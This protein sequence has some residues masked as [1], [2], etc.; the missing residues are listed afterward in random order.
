M[1]TS[2]LSD[3]FYTDHAYSNEHAMTVIWCVILCEVSISRTSQK[4]LPT[5]LGM[6]AARPIPANDKAPSVTHEWNWW[7]VHAHR[8]IHTPV[9]SF[10]PNASHRSLDYGGVLVFQAGWFPF[11]YC[12]VFGRQT[13]PFLPLFGF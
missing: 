2:V 8:C 11:C 3:E 10:V 1:P 5:C 9:L 4:A 13:L 7:A 6:C 12:N